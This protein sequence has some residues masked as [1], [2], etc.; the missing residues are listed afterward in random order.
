MQ[1]SVNIDREF[2]RWS[3][4]EKPN[5][6][7]THSLNRNLSMWDLSITFLV[8]VYNSLP[9]LTL[10]KHLCPDEQNQELFP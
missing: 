8:L 2:V 9:K 4:Q 6:K 5:F 1:E 10:L 3:T 7:P